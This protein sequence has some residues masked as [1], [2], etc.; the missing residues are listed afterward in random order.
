Q[1]VAQGQL[2]RRLVADWREAYGR[3]SAGVGGAVR[4][5]GCVG[6]VH[7]GLGMQQ[8]RH[9]NLSQPMLDLKG[10]YWKHPAF[11]EGRREDR[12]PYQLLGVS[13]TTFDFWGLLN[14]DPEELAQEL[15][16]SGLAA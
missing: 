1:A 14:S 3:V 6:G 7:S 4:A 12:C 9:R 13:L 10:V 8:A 16:S 2:C 15:S 11:P 5:S